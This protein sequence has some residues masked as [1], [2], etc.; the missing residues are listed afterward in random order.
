M[1]NEQCVSEIND[2]DKIWTW[3]NLLYLIYGSETI[4]SFMT[5]LKR[6]IIGF[7][8]G[9]D[10]IEKFFKQNNISAIEQISKGNEFDLVLTATNH[11]ILNNCRL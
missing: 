7:H 9:C 1:N 11:S 3:E 8:S 2:A 6:H 4:E 5:N 10:S